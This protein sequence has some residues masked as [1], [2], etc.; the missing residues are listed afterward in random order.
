MT[1]K[2]YRKRI[3]AFIDILGFKHLVEKSKDD[4]NAAE[5]IHY[6]LN[7]IRSIKQSNNIK[8][9]SKVTGIQASTF[10]DCAVISYPVDKPD[11]FFNIL[12]DLIH[13]QLDLAY[14]GVL[15]RGGVT[16]G[17]L[18]HK[19]DIVYGP[20]M[21][22]AASMEKDIAI[23]PRI[24]LT[25]ETLEEGI[26]LSRKPKMSPYDDS[27]EVDEQTI[28]SFVRRD[29][30]DLYFLDMLKQDQEIN[31]DGTEYY[32]W[33]IKVK[34]LI[35][36]GLQENSNNLRVLMKY[37]WMKKYFN[38]VVTD[39]H[40]YFPIPGGLDEYESRQFRDGYKDLKIS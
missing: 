16:I 2:N 24:V 37:R 17:E 36:D 27:S 23:Y 32:D 30:D 35:E 25:E 34:N 6:A 20:A 40:A 9:Y 4:S 29:M 1:G 12:L 31:D 11:S 38:S 3:V 19:S 14:R 5:E 39:D 7:R 28:R 21:N 13:L 18:Y 10:S 26:Q 33:L 8:G 15:I 22:Q